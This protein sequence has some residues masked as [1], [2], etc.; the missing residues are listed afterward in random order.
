[1]TRVEKE[2]PS[3]DQHSTLRTQQVKMC[4]KPIR[5]SR[6]RRCNNPI[7][8]NGGADCT[9]D[10]VGRGDACGTGTPCCADTSGAWCEKDWCNYPHTEP[11]DYFK[12]HCKKTCDFC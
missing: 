5:F 3:P 7:P 10:E 6:T 11:K 2:M 9:G 12:T 4:V 1:M 8:L